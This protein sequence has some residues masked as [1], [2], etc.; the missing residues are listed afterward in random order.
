M[1]YLVTKTVTSTQVVEDEDGAG[2]ALN[3]ALSYGGD[4]RWSDG[5]VAYTVEEV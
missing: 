3:E 4:Y 2:W 5:K 1:K